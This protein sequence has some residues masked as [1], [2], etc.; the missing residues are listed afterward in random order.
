[1]TGPDRANPDLARYHR[2]ML[3]AGIGEAG[4]RALLASRVVIIGCGALGCASADLLARAGVG[5]LTLIDRDVVELT[6]LQRQTLY[7]EADA[8]EGAPKA[9]AAARRLADVNS[10]IRIRP[11]IADVTHRNVERLVG[12]GGGSGAGGP[13]VLVDGTDNFHTRYLLN[14]AAVKHGAPYIY[15]GAVGTT[16]M[17]MPVLPGRGPCLRCIFDEPPAAGTT[18]TCDTAGVL[19]PVVAM[20]AAAQAAEA[21]RVLVAG[22]ASVEPGL[23][24]FDAWNGRVRRIEV[25]S[26]RRAECA[27]CGRGRYEYLDGSRAEDTAVLCGQRAVQVWPDSAQAGGL[28]DLKGLAARL[29][30]H[31]P[32]TAH[33]YLLR[34]RLE[35]ERG[36]EGA[37]IELT[38]FADGR[39]VVRGTGEVSEARAIYA[40]YVGA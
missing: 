31:G 13:V 34:A 11:V 15:G 27:A 5:E 14:D 9:E 17:V 20:V 39:A 6:N 35:R 7:C 33:E 8:A 25:G 24:E 36:R 12:L 40:R 21:I 4:Q 18:P 23:L 38:V 10:A 19:G 32:V 37:V 28:V 3:L 16:G 2:Q 1:M 30:E 22:P 29:R 26:A